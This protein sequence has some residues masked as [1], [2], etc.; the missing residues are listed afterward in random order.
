MKSKWWIVISLV[1]LLITVW[2]YNRDIGVKVVFCDVGQGDGMLL[3]RGKFQMLVDVGGKN[4]KMLRCLSQHMPFWDKRIEVVVISH[5]DSDH[6]GGLEGVQKHYRVETVYS[7]VIPPKGNEQYIYPT[8]VTANDVIRYGDIDFEILSI[9][10]MEGDT[11]EKSLVGL[12]GYKDLSGKRVKILMMGDTP[13]EVEQGLVWN[14]VLGDNVGNIDI[15]KVSHHGSGRAT[16]EELL[17]E[18][19]PIMAVIS[20]GKNNKFGHPAKEVL[21]KLERRGIRVRR[22]DVEG[23]VLVTH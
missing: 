8:L 23:D 12:V 18:I 5:W 9:G 7:N 4:Q 6:S 11:N 10:D 14:G 2:Q 1:V 17:D 15:L 19:R 13:M 21:E 22:T 20:V 16:A 3:Q